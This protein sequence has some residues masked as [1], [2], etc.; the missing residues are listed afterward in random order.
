MKEKITFFIDIILMSIIG[1]IQSLSLITFNGI[2]PNFVLAV[3]V[4]LIFFEKK[5]LRYAILVLTAMICLDYSAFISKE[6]VIFGILMLSAFYFKKYL[7]ENIFLYSFLFT[8]ILTTVF[9]L[10]IDPGF[11]FNDFNLFF[12]ELFYNVSTSSIFGFLYQIGYEKK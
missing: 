9:Y 11:I 4:I 7:S 1:L 12:L 10:L 5:F 2:K 3:L 8:S 6:V